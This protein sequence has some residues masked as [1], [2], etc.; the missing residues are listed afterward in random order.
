MGFIFIFLFA[1]FLFFPENI[2]GVTTTITNFPST[3]SSEPFT[4]DVK[5]SGASSG[6][7]YLKVDLYKP[8]TI[9]YF[10]ETYSGTN[11]YNGG[12]HVQYYPA[13]IQSGVDWT[14]QIQ[15]R[16]GNPNSSQYDAPGQYK[17]RVRRYTSSGNYNSTEA[18][19][20]A[21]DVNITVLLPTATP[22]EAP[23]NTPTPTE[24][25]T[26]TQT[27]T[28]IENE[29]PTP[30]PQSY[31]N[32]FLS[33]AMIGP[34]SEN[35]EWIEIY[36]RNDFSVSLDNWFIDDIENGGTTPK[37]FSLTISAKSY[38]VYELTT[39]MFNNDG[40]SVRL[41]DYTQSEKD[42]FQYQSSEKGKTLART[43]F[44]SDTFC[45]QNPSKGS[46]NDSCTNPSATPTP[47]ITPSST[48]T[49]TRTPTSTPTKKV[50]PTVSPTKAKPKA[51][52]TKFSLFTQN[53][54]ISPKKQDEV[55]EGNILGAET[56]EKSSAKSRN[57]LL[58]SL[59]F[60]AFSFAIL[61][62]ASIIIKTKI[63][64]K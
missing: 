58:N 52:P 18:N 27:P 5:I 25:V 33:E 63:R 45:L 38:G 55:Y 14:G 57:P 15:T 20:S 64:K 22:T 11:W 23:T 47:K 35:V 50:T 46:V 16:T 17:M 13:S 48:I 24:V 49:P 7:N 53:K 21:V 12:D 29:N 42:S 2:F 4:L 10:G 30:T 28:I 26:P 54:V 36:N 37:K 3:V 44:D 19:T 6:T 60:A 8:A 59:L 51:T 40:D 61:A 32:I 39:S 9:N 43:S 34:E 41:L 1:I 56:K 31:S 62:I